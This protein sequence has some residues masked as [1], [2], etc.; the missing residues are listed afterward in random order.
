MLRPTWAQLSTL[1][2][3]VGQFR[4]TSASLAN[5]AKHVLPHVDIQCVPPTY[6]IIPYY[7][8]YARSV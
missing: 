1:P 7:L 6:H 2:F 4:N 5:L 8:V 3:C